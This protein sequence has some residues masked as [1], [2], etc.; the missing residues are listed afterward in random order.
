MND[1]E[2][3]INNKEDYVATGMVQYQIGGEKYTGYSDYSFIW[4]LSYNKSPERSQS[5]ATGDLDTNYSTFLTAHM[6]ATYSLMTIDDYRRIMKQFYS[7]RQFSV[8]CYDPVYDKMIT[9]QMYFATPSTPK[10]R[11][12]ANDDGT[13]S[14][15]GVDN[16]TVE[17]IGTNNDN[18]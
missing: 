10:F 3:I 14:L 15:V 17:L 6:I 9:K 12:I 18:N 4:E 13:V 7:K 5:G 2:E 11:Y 8:R 16:Y 1:I